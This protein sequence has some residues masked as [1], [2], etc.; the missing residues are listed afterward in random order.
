MVGENKKYN[1]V[2]KIINN[3]NGMEY[4]GV[5]STD[6]LDDGY[7]GSG[8]YLRNAIRKYGQSNFKKEILEYCNSRTEALNKEKEIVC[9]D[10]IRKRKVYNL[11]LGGGSIYGREMS[12]H[13][14]KKGEEDQ[15]FIDYSNGLKQENYIQ[16]FESPIIFYTDEHELGNFK[17]EVEACKSFYKS[18]EKRNAG[19]EFVFMLT[20]NV[21]DAL[22][23][24]CKIITNYWNDKRYHSEALKL[25]K[26]L[27]LKN[28]V[29]L[30]NTSIVR[31]KR[32]E[33]AA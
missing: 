4:T 24:M 10:Y 21:L 32:L 5:H 8:T 28:W 13:K 9:V 27:L 14:F 18:F 2:Y 15:L 33:K 29:N 16:D 11:V 20:L 1:Y 17:Q 23:D 12:V 26:K 30:S 3:L 25:Y 22:P 7:M 19:K 31:I 6:N